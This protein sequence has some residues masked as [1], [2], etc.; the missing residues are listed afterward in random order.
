MMFSDNIY[1][2]YYFYLYFWNVFKI[3]KYIWYFMPIY[4]LLAIF[5]LYNVLKINK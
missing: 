4:I 1:F 5:I 2:G 3:T